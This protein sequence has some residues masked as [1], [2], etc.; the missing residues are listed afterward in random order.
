MGTGDAGVSSAGINAK[1]YGTKTSGTVETILAHTHTH[2]STYTDI[3]GLSR[4][5]S[6]G[7]GGLLQEYHVMSTE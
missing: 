4:V 6:R 5:V 7:S 3:I 2:C 1:K